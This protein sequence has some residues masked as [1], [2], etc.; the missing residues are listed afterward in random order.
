[1]TVVINL[2]GFD[3]SI[4][5]YY[6]Y[7]DSKNDVK[8]LSCLRYGEFLYLSNT[9]GTPVQGLLTISVTVV[10]TCNYLSMIVKF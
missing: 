1:M 6:M 7:I 5:L 10:V 3:F 2:E 9:K 4:I 8:T